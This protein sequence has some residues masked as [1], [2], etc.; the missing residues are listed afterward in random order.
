MIPDLNRETFK[1]FTEVDQNTW[2]LLFTGLEKNRRDMAYEI[3]EKGILALGI[4]G[5]SIPKLE[6]VNTRLFHL[7][8]WKGVPVAGL[9]SA[10]SFYP[11][12]ARKEFPIG[13][14]IR[15]QDDL[16][17]TPEP[18][19][20]HDLYG[21]LPFYVDA[22]YADYCYEYGKMTLQFLD[23]P[24]KFR[25]AERFFWFAV[26]FGLIETPVGRRIFGAGILSSKAESEYA[27]SNQPE[28][29]PFSVKALCDQEFRIDEFQKR[30]FILKNVDQ[31]YSSLSDVV[32][33]LHQA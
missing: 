2:K 25:M 12:L 9:E 3:F 16:G 23:N 22:R 18:D 17:Y 30:L 26:E 7:T 11:A 27:L 10:Q 15:S 4:D 31:L 28:V 6:H 14:F 13:N 21:H 32:N 1:S 33:Y 8:G 19:V 24:K 5:S 20:F 29:V